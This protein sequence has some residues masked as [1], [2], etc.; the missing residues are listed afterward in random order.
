MI[1]RI[2]LT[3][4]IGSGKTTVADMF[5]ELGIMIIDADEIARTLTAKNAPCVDLIAEHFGEQVLLKKGELNRAA[6]RQIIF[7]KP[8]AKNWLEQLLH[9]RIRHIIKEEIE[10]VTSPYCVVVIPLLTESKG[11][12]FIDRILVVDAPEEMQIDRVKARDQMDDATVKA[13]IQS[14]SD[15]KKRLAMADDI[16]EN[17]GNT[18]QLRAQVNEI[19]QKYLKLLISTIG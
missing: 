8:E 15:R 1:L 5:A 7:N 17:G 4:G 18:D 2:G 16:I 14:Q 13:I 11:I 6:L 3:G 12:D 9:P 10:Q 19:H